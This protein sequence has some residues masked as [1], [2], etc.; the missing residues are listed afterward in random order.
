MKM[1]A[2][3]GEGLALKALMPLDKLLHRLVHT[4]SLSQ[5]QREGG[6]GRSQIPRGIDSEALTSSHSKVTWPPRAK[7]DR[8]PRAT[9][10]LIPRSPA[11]RVSSTVVLSLL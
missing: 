5:R 9:L 2:S 1:I 10:P 3:L 7:L 4:F 6:D 11:W 8:V